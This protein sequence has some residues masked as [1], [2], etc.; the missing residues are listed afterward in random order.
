MSYIM[1]NRKELLSKYPDL[2]TS[3]LFLLPDLSNQMND[4]YSYYSLVIIEPHIAA[5]Y[6]I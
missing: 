5:L 2:L 3:F 4:E 6:Q 1:C